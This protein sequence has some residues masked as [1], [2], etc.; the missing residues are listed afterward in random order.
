LRGTSAAVSPEARGLAFPRLGRGG[1]SPRESA[2]PTGGADAQTALTNDDRDAQT[3]VA[4]YLDALRARDVAGL[5]R[6]LH[7]RVKVVYLR[8][9]GRARQLTRAAWLR[10]FETR[11]VPREEVLI[12]ARALGSRQAGDRAV[13]RIE[14]RYPGGAYAEWLWLRRLGP[15]WSVVANVIRWEDAADA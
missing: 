6:A 1:R 15:R 12:A 8:G 3:A 14:R 13:A 7:P 5:R 11:P 9:D 4:L 2:I 10:Q